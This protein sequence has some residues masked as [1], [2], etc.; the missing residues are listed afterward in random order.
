MSYKDEVQEVY[1]KRP[2][3]ID[4]NRLLLFRVYE[5][6]GLKLTPEQWKVVEKLPQP[7]TIRRNGAKIRNT[8]KKYSFKRK[9]MNEDEGPDTPTLF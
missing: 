8:R 4:D 3:T 2:E 9:Y 1:D 7:E 6:H 5:R